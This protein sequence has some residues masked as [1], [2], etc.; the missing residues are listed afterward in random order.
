VLTEGASKEVLMDRAVWIWN[1]F[2]D[3]LDASCK[4]QSK[5]SESL[6]VRAVLLVV[7]ASLNP[8]GFLRGGLL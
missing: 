6:F 1:G 7:L 5:S 3:V 4:L 8:N 2:Y